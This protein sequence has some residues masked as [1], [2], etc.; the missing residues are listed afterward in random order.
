MLL[1]LSTIVYYCVVLLL[2]P[3]RSLHQLRVRFFFFCVYVCLC[4]LFASPRRMVM[5]G[6]ELTGKSPFDTIYLHG[7]AT[8][9]P[10]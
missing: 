2:G 1:L 6:I 4:V 8:D 3:V 7:E 10:S 5:M 9:N